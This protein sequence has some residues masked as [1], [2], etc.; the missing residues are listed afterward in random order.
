M[1]NDEAEILKNPHTFVWCNFKLHISICC[2]CNCMSFRIKMSVTCSTNSNQWCR[3][4][5]MCFVLFQTTLWCF[6]DY[7]IWCLHL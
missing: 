4:S 7:E 1:L 3:L 2:V 5:F 6:L